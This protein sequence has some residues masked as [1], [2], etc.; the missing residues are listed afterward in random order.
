M[1]LEI[2][3]CGQY[4]GTCEFLL[5]DLHKVEQVLGLSATNVIDGIRR[6]GQAILAILTLRGALHHTHNALHDVIDK[7]EIATAVTIVEDLDGLA[8]QQFV[9]ETE[10]GHVGTSG[11]TIDGEETQ[12]CGGDVVEL[13]I[14]VGK[15]LVR[16]LGGCIERHGIIH[17]VV[18]R[19]RNFL[20]A[21]IDTRA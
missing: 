10:I 13:R 21:A 12:T 19:E 8:L 9:G 2:E 20:V 5:Q 6:D 17:A 1:G 15:E 11:R 3:V 14:A 18:G 4:T 16:L 7:G